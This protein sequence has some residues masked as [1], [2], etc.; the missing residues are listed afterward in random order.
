MIR[1]VPL[2]IQPEPYI[3]RVL[4]KHTRLILDSRRVRPS[5][6]HDSR[7]SRY[8]AEHMAEISG[9]PAERRLMHGVIFSQPKEIIR[10]CNKPITRI[11]QLHDYTHNYH[12]YAPR[13][14]SN[15]DK[16]DRN[17]WRVI[18]RAYGLMYCDRC[19]QEI[20]EREIPAQVIGSTG[21]PI[22]VHAESCVYYDDVLVVRVTY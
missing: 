7:L 22:L 6:A 1:V 21:K 17:K 4:I 18:G 20:T 19:W 12:D 16:S 10:A 13:D 5:P 3:R 15:G 2:T 8:V 14:E 9:S 11:M